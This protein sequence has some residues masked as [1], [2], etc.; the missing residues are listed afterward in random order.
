MRSFTLFLQRV[1]RYILGGYLGYDTV[2]CRVV[3]KPQM[4]RESGVQRVTFDTCVITYFARLQTK[5]IS[6]TP[7]TKATPSP[8]PPRTTTATHVTGYHTHTQHSI[9]NTFPRTK[10]TRR[11]RF[12]FTSPPSPARPVMVK[13]RRFVYESIAFCSFFFFG[14][15]SRG[16]EE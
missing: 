15:I 4:K 5:I 13:F 12:I 2:H 10:K 7:Q 16:T 8:S 9:D 1:L 11:C 3:S 6:H 14:S